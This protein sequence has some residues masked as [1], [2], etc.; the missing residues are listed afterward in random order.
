MTSD[1]TSTIAA[2][3][4]GLGNTADAV[5]DQLRARAIKGVRN[6]EC[7]CPIARL[8]LTLPGVDQVEVGPLSAD[9]YPTGVYW[10]VEVDLPEAAT[11]FIDH[12]DEGVYLDLVEIPAVA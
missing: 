8:L 10:P 1:L 7:N 12:F 6:D 3:L 11:A 5:A 4:A 9:I 2:T